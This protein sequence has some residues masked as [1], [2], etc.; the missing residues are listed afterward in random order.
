MKSRYMLLAIV[1]LHLC[2]ITSATSAPGD[3]NW[4]DGFAHQGINGNVHALAVYNGE[5]IAAGAFTR[6]GETAARNI[7]RWD[8]SRWH[9]LG[10]GL[11]FQVE[12]LA[13]YQGELVAGGYWPYSVDSKIARWDGVSWKPLGSGLRCDSTYCSDVEVRAMAVFNGELIVGG[14]FSEAGGVP[15]PGSI[16]RWDGVSWMP[17]SADPPGYW[18]DALGVYDSTL[19]AGYCCVCDVYHCHTLVSLWDGQSW[20]NIGEVSD[21]VNCTTL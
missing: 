5:L 6:A 18:V 21:G 10:A 2:A 9:A 12:D 1:T 13:V 4:W 19:V 3:E 15:V 11:D 20:R 8:G 16:A 7:A 14:M 17:L